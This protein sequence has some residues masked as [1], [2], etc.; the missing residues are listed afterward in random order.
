MKDLIRDDIQ[1]NDKYPD[2]FAKKFE[3]LQDYTMVRLT[4]LLNRNYRNKGGGGES[5]SGGNNENTSRGSFTQ[6][7]GENDGIVLGTND[8]TL[9]NLPSVVLNVKRKNISATTIQLDVK[10][11][12]YS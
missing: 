9:D 7:D 10:E 12:N 1:G 5:D 8:V 4:F 3:L 11:P 2:T 6:T